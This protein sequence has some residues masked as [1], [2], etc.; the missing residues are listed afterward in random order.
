MLVILCAATGA[1]AQ[2]CIDTAPLDTFGDCFQAE[3][4][5]LEA[6]VVHLVNAVRSRYRADPERLRAFDRSADA[7]NA[8]RNSRC[9]AEA[10][11]KAPIEAK[12]AFASCTKRAL[13][14]RAR[15]LEAL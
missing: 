7:W 4:L 13:E 1:R 10:Q 8:E 3:I 5:P 11:G 15:E 6:K 9:S 14:A 12:R 2:S